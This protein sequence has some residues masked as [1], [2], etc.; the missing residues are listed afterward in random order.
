MT[1]EMKFAQSAIILVTDVQAIHP[2]I[3]PFVEV[4]IQFR[5]ELYQETIVFVIPGTTI[6]E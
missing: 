4:I 5:I 3:V 6:M 2:T 1:W